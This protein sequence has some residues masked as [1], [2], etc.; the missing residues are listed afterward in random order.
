M[1][2]ILYS[3]FIVGCCSCTG[4]NE[5]EKYQG[6]RKNIIQVRDKVEEIKIEEPLIN[7]F[8][9]LY[10]MDDYLIIQDLR[11]LDKL[12]HLF[13]KNNFAYIGSIAER[14]QGPNE[15]TNM[16]LITIDEAQRS[17]YVADHGKQK[18][19]SYDLDSVVS[20]A[21]S[22]TPEVKME[23]DEALFP[24]YY[25]IVND[26]IS[27][28]RIIQLIGTND[29][30]PRVGKVNMITG[31]ITFMKYEHP[32]I[33]DRKRSGVVA[34]IEHGIYV[35]YYSEHDLMTI[36]NLNG[37]LICDVYGPDWDIT[38][39]PN[40]YYKKVIFCGDKIYA[41]YLGEKGGITKEGRS[42]LAT[43]ILVF[44]LQG[45]YIQTLETGLHIND[46]CYDKENNRIILSL[47]DEI[48]FGYLYI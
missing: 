32:K 7:S 31:E 27:I 13:D 43:K 37:D 20:H 10:L 18:I 14:G 25:Q 44:D 46:F 42:K 45:N 9:R 17:F 48:Q 34:S 26:S 24:D 21:S 36:C 16:G 19:F 39:G 6:T 15:I 28:C 40:D 8:N 3:L 30:K 35:E 41:K 33:T 5:T 38:R 47:N 2:R 29:F 12:I 22:Y 1:N 11:G 23:M 4:S